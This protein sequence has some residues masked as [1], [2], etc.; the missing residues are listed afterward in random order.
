[1]MN[2]TAKTDNAA[3]REELK[4]LAEA[5]KCKSNLEKI[6]ECKKILTLYPYGLQREAV[7]RQIKGYENN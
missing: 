7:E 4:R 1:M 5:W 3:W 2:M 6:A